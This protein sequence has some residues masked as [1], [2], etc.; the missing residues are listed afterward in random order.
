MT[1][2]TENIDSSTGSEANAGV[3]DFSTENNQQQQSI[4]NEDLK[5]PL[6][7]ATQFEQETGYKDIHSMNESNQKLQSKLQNQVDYYKDKFSQAQISSAIFAESSEAI[8]SPLIHEILGNKCKCD[9]HGN[10]TI[11]G[12]AVSD[13]VKNLL[14]TYPSLA[15]A[16]GD[17]GSGAPISV[18]SANTMNRSAYQQLSQRERSEFISKGGK[19]KD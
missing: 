16:R 13:A 10:V 12:M 7:Y 8:S 4:A 6:D 1:D 15:K 18:S 2:I 5:Q 17:A 14:N 9:E 3:E 19:L 11:D